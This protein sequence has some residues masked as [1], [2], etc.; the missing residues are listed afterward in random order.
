MWQDDDSLRLKLGAAG[1]LMMIFT[2]SLLDNCPTH[3]NLGEVYSCRSCMGNSGKEGISNFS[4]LCQCQG[5]K[6]VA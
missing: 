5:S 2:G 6:H 1:I 3:K 4:V